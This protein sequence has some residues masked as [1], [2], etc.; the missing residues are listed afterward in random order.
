MPQSLKPTLS[1][2][3]SSSRDGTASEAAKAE[4]DRIF[5]E[6]RE[7]IHN[8]DFGAATA[9]VFDDMLDRSVPFY[10][11][12]QRMIGELCSDF[13][14]PGTNV[15]DLGCSTCNTFFAI[16]NSIPKDVTCI[17]WDYSPEMIEKGRAKLGRPRVFTA[18][19][20]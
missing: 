12:I 3:A 18:L 7:M 5:S 4:K 17:G 15:Y 10:Q 9:S 14:A 13:A 6:K 16:E 8:F 20:T 1:K 19:R 11:E 2:A